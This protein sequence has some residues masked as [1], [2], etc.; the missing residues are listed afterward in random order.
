[1]VPALCAVPCPDVWV[2]VQGGPTD[3]HRQPGT[4]RSRLRAWGDA[5][6]SW[7]HRTQ[8]NHRVDHLKNLDPLAREAVAHPG[9][10]PQLLRF[11]WVTVAKQSVQAVLVGAPLHVVPSVPVCLA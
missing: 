8:W 6:G 3:M 5:N 2:L 10:A 4:G 11:P 1:M 7:C 9:L